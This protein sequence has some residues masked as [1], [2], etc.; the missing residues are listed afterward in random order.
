MADV[1][2]KPEER[3]LK[4]LEEQ[5]RAELQ[6]ELERKVAQARPASGGAA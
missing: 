2:H 5:R 4:R 1:P 3:A 6:Q